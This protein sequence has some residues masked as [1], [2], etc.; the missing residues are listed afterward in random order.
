MTTRA[1][2][3]TARLP[4]P[5]LISPGRPPNIAVTNPSITAAYNPT[6]GLTCASKAKA[7]TSGLSLSI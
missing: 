6:K 1:T 4:A 2:L 7:T 5:P 3:T